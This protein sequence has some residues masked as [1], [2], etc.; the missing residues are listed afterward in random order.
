ME[1]PKK[2]VYSRKE[3]GMILAK[4]REFVLQDLLPDSDINKILIF[5]SL[6]KG[7]FGEYERSWR[8]GKFSDIDVLILADDNFRPPKEW[9]VWTGHEKFKVYTH[10]RLDNKYLIQYMVWKEKQYSDETNKREVEKWG[11]PLKKKSINKS[12]LIYE[13][14]D[15]R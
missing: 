1:R 5:G 9:K 4:A 12:I 11:I 6:A 8:H 3:Q 2:T 15:S 10:G 13:K 14:P 7:T